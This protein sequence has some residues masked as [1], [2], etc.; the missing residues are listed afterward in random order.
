MKKIRVVVIGI[1]CISLVVG[2][3]YHLSNKSEEAKE[4]DLT[5]VQKVILKDLDGKEYPETPREVVK[6]YNRILCCYYNEEYSEEEFEKLADQ[7]LKL[8]DEE[9]AANNPPKQYYLRVKTEVE[10]YHEKNRTINNASV[11][12]SNEVKYATIDGA[13]CAYVAASYFVR[14]DDGFTKSNQ[15][16]VLRKDTEG[17]WKILAFE[18]DKG[19]TTENE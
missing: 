12:D 3:Y 9:L 14:D 1:I 17:R 5:E 4:T 11:C 6:L 8:M 10:S 13:E 19:D 7:A 15:N 2:Y 18:L 16:Y